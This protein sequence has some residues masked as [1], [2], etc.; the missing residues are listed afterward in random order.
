MFYQIVIKNP[1]DFSCNSALS[2]AMLEMS[3]LNCTLA[4]QE[5]EHESQQGCGLVIWLFN[6]IDLC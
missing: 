3:L 1:C 4:G 6:K 5:I 2:S